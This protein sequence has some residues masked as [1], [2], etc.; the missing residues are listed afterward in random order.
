MNPPPPSYEQMGTLNNNPN[1]FTYSQ[2]T[3]L[4]SIGCTI[5]SAYTILAVVFI[6][7][8]VNKRKIVDCEGCN[9]T[10][11]DGRV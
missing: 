8:Y 3:A 5:V 9:K 2:F 6:K 7:E 11:N 1:Q 4:V 10:V